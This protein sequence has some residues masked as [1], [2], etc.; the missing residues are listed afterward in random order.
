V[1]PDVNVQLINKAAGEVRRPCDCPPPHAHIPR[2]ATTPHVA[3]AIGTGAGAGA[4]FYYPPPG[5]GGAGGQ[6]TAKPK[7]PDRSFDRA[8]PAICSI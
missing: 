7:I 4:G 6:T 2:D 1:I 5:R 3:H 8:D